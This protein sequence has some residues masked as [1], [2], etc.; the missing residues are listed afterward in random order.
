MIKF[1]PQ[2]ET[3]AILL[4]FWFLFT[5]DFSLWN[6]IVGTIISV[7][8]TRFSFG[9]VYDDSDFIV[10]IPNVFILIRY[11]FRLIYEIYRA[12]FL[13][14]IRILKKDND[15]VIVK[16][17][18]DITDPFLIT[19]IAN[20]ITLTP[21]TITVDAVDNILYVLYIKDDGKDGEKLKKDIKNRFEKYFIKKG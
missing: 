6:S 10:R 3:F 17:E 4:L 21:G 19:I 8:I 11:S 14:I 20:S 15:S 5:L 2:Y 1:K 18:L 9:I 7:I 13:Q 12:S 16:V